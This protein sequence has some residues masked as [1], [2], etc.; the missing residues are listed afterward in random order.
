MNKS[1]I[2]A[3]IRSLAMSKGFYGRLLCE[4]EANPEALDYLEAQNFSDSLD[5]VLFLEG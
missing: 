2:I 4:L 1:Q 3:A 5:M